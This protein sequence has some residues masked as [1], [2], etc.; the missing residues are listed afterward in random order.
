MS[1]QICPGCHRTVQPL[2]RIEK[3]KKAKKTYRITYCPYDRCNFNLDIEPINV[4]LWNSKDC[5]FEDETD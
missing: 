2:D 1:H 5:S 3:D 4:K